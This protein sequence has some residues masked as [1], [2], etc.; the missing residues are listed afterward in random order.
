M[1]AQFQ[2]AGQDFF[3]KKLNFWHE[4]ATYQKWSSKHCDD[5]WDIKITIVSFILDIY[6]DEKNCICML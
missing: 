6:R 5:E 4:H 1:D 2:A 3:I